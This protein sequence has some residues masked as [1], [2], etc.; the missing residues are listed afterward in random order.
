MDSAYQW[1][2]LKGLMNLLETQL[3]HISEHFGF[4]V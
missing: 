4:L 2:I 1:W 3:S